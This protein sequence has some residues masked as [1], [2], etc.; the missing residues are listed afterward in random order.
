MLVLLGITALG[1]VVLASLLCF[2][3]MFWLYMPIAVVF[4]NLRYLY[5][6]I[7]LLLYGIVTCVNHVRM[8][9]RWVANFLLV[10]MAV[11][12]IAIFPQKWRQYIAD[13]HVMTDAVVAAANWCN[14]HLPPSAVILVH[15]AGYMAVATQFHLIDLVGLKTPATIYYQQKY[16]LDGCKMQRGAAT[17]AVIHR[18]HPDY[19]ITLPEWEQGFGVMRNRERLGWSA[20]LLY[21]TS[22]EGYRIYK[23]KILN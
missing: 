11:C 12:A 22:A 19:M 7:P 5:P 2:L 13:A 14:T 4:N 18:Y 6:L 16:F 3:A 15:D 21:K 23:V 10:L 17:A 20:K 9:M 8:E 1:R